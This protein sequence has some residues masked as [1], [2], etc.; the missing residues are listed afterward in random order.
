MGR[1]ENKVAIVTGG[2][3]GLGKA[4]AV[5]YARE[6]ASIIIA[7][8]NI[9]AAKLTA[10]EITENGGKAIAVKTNVT[11][12]DDIQQMVDSA[13]EAFG[14]V[15]ILVNNAGIVDNMY[16]AGTITDEVW[17]RVFNINVTGNM[18][19][20]RK[21]LPIF[22]EKK[23]GVIVNMSSI[24]GLEGGRGGLAYTASKHAIVGMTKNIASHYGEMNIRCNA[25]APA[26]V[27]TDLA[28][29]M[30]QPDKFGME[31]ALRGVNL[32]VRPGKVEEIANIALFLASD[33]S[34]YVNGHVIAADAGWSAY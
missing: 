4:I 7:D 5:T 17:E 24:S 23:A 22:E 9:D 20:T 10:N 34:S 33:E 12:E 19:A 3:A 8:M 14:T 25:I 16:A 15:D 13:V 21:V 2:G 6:G 30:R 11:V 27:P 18:R 29:T 31:Q 28:K 32:L 26:Q 1:L